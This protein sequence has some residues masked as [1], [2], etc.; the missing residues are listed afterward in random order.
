MKKDI[1][2]KRIKQK[3]DVNQMSFLDHIRELRGRLIVSCIACVVCSIVAFIFFD[4]I[5]AILYK[6]FETIDSSMNNA[7]L[8]IKSL[9]EGV[10]VKFKISIIAGFIL[11]LPV[12][13]YN[14]LKFIFP[15]LKKKEKKVII[16]SLVSSFF[17]IASSISYTYFQ[18]IPVSVEFL[19]GSS[20][21]PENT[22]ILLTYS[23]NI[24][25]ILQFLLVS[26]LMFQVPILLE[27]LLIL[28]I[29]RRKSLFRA[30]R[31]VIIVILVL[32]AI[33][34]PPDVVSQVAL[35]VPLIALYFLT[36]VI[37]KIFHF[38][39][40]EREIKEKYKPG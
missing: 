1:N 37:A 40:G 29:I 38:G 5:V 2:G 28:N 22:G 4:P 31:I 26:L 27:V 23:D 24:F 14:L 16:I 25:Y 3:K 32:A 36:I 20:F 30:S 17:L 35:A 18:I 9:F 21:I 8:Y 11:S 7:D 34:T 6:P 19:T 12:H 15:G 13:L 39:E 10:I 33:L